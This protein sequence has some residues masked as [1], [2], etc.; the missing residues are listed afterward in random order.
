MP[1]NDIK[2]ALVRQIE[3]SFSRLDIDY[4]TSVQDNY[5]VYQTAFKK[6]AR[7]TYCYIL[8]KDKI[9]RTNHLNTVFR[10]KS[11]S[12]ITS[13]F[14]DQEVCELARNWTKRF[15]RVWSSETNT[16]SK[17]TE[18]AIVTDQYG[19]MITSDDLD[20][21]DFK[22]VVDLFVTIAVEVGNQAAIRKNRDWTRFNELIK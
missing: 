16:S 14:E 7:R 21:A 4:S 8:H 1:T 12:D 20:H 19:I 10:F 6:N 22:I 13:W 5:A 15:K 3:Y 18:P 11:K 2:S 17:F 9:N